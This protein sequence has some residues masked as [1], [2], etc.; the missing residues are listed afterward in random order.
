MW[1]FLILIFLIVIDILDIAALPLICLLLLTIFLK[2]KKSWV[3]GFAFISGLI[4]DILL[5]RPFGQT[6][7]FF[8]TFVF[9]VLLYGRK[10]EIQSPFFILL[11]AFLGEILY[12]FL[13]N[14]NYAIQQAF[15]SS[16]AAI[17]LWK[18]IHKIALI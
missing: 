14:Y 12:L 13:F 16:V 8:V 9:I 18:I 15:I 17:I 11:S 6:S 10:F 5:A 7:L 1:F 4:V 3:F 2:D